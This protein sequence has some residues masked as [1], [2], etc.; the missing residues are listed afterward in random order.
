MTGAEEVSC[1]LEDGGRVREE[2]ARLEETIV[3]FEEVIEEEF[4]CSVDA[5][6]DKEDVSVLL[7][8]T[9]FISEFN[10]S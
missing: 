10:S 4:A 8:V 3:L 1:R 6:S 5:S 2:F 7:A 9:S